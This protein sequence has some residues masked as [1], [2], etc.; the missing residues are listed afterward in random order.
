M[1][2][3]SMVA[4]V[5]PMSEDG[6]LDLS[7]FDRLV[8]FHVEQGTCALVVAGTT[9]ESATLSM[10]EHAELVRRAVNR[11]RERVPVIAGTGSASTATTIALTR[12]A[13]AAGVDACLIVTPYYNKPV[14][15]GLYRHYRAV[16]EAVAVPQILYNVPSRTGCDLLPETVV[17]LAE[18]PNIVGIKEAT[19]SLE[20]AR[21]LRTLCSGRLD[22]YSGDD[23]TA[24]EL[25]LDGGQGVIS[26][27]A[28]VA[29]KLMAEMCASALAGDAAAAAS[30]DARLAG[31]H[32]ALFTESNPIP[33][34]WALHA[35]GLIGPAL[36]LPLTPLADAKHDEVAQALLQ[37][38]IAVQYA[39]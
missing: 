19:G 22:V 35:M 34:K 7:A 38:G 8:D 10:A 36:R 33:A 24:R 14:Q 9:G 4:L 21:Q 25:M 28:N 12:Q 23:A 13:M 31:L 5:T 30:A 2:R 6:L 27:T 3:G 11:T 15:E 39:A 20:R 18:F 17:R 32:R 29:P 37:A 1:F 26:V 16:A